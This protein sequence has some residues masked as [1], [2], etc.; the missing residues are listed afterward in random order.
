MFHWYKGML[1]PLVSSQLVVCVVHKQE[2]GV[3]F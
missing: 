2:D 3:S 1:Y